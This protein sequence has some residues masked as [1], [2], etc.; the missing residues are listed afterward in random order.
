MLLEN[1]PLTHSHDAPNMVKQKYNS[2][3]GITKFHVD[4]IMYL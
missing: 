4:N 1:V 2:N 3:Y